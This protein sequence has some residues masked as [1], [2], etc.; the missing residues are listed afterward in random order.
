MASVKK[1]VKSKVG[2]GLKKLSKGADWIGFIGGYIGTVM[3]AYGGEDGDILGGMIPMHVNAVV[4]HNVWEIADTPNRMQ[5]PNWNA[6]LITGIIMTVGGTVAKYLPSFVPHQSTAAN[7]ITKGGY[8]LAIGSATAIVVSE[9][10]MG[11]SPFD[12]SS[13]SGGGGSNVW[14]VPKS[15]GVS[16]V[17]MQSRPTASTQYASPE[18]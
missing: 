2:Q 1:T 11:S 6:L 4:R 16:N 10:A 17:G 8:G 13:S 9:L 3:G 15:T 5:D 18:R 12:K 7:I 14:K